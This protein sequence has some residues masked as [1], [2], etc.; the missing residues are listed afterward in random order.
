[1]GDRDSIYGFGAVGL[2]TFCV[3]DTAKASE[4]LMNLCAKDYAVVYITEALAED[5]KN[6]ISHFSEKMLPAIIL[7][8]GVSGNTGNALKSVRTLAKRAVGRDIIFGD[9]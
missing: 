2:E 3:T 5:L 8:P 9:D 6:E 1:M 4:I 7:I